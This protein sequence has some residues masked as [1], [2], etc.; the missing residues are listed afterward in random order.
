MRIRVVDRNLLRSGK[1]PDSVLREKLT[2]IYFNLKFRL[3]KRHSHLKA[4]VT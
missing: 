4:A 2:I 3:N 1:K